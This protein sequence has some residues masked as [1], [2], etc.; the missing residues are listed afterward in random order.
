MD[1]LI[2]SELCMDWRQTIGPR[3]FLL[4]LWRNPDQLVFTAHR[5]Y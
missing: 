2:R 5:R 4:E 1:S 3:Q